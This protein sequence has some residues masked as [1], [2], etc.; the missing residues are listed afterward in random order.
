MHPIAQ[1]RT[2][3][4]WSIAWR[5]L[6]LVAVLLWCGCTAARRPP[7]ALASGAGGRS[8]TL[9][10]VR[11]S[12]SGATTQVVITGSGPMQPLVQRLSQPDRLLIELPYT[13]LPAPWNQGAI[14]VGDGRLKTMQTTH[15]PQTG[16]SVVLT[17]NAIRDYRV[18]VQSAP[19]RVIVE[20]FGAETAVR[21]RRKAH[22]AGTGGKKSVARGKATAAAP[23]HTPQPPPGQGPLIVIDPGHGGHDPGTQGVAGVVE[24]TVVLQIA[25]ALRQRIRE[26]MPHYRVMLTRNRDVFIPLGER[27]RM[28]NVAKARVFISIHANSSPNREASGL[29]VW[30]LSFAASARAKQIAAR[31][32]MLS[33]Q[34]QSVL[35]RILRDMQETD[36]INQSAVLAQTTHKA[37]V[38]HLA[39][40][41]PGLTPRGVEGAPF[42]VL[43]RTQMPS[44]LIETGFLSNAEEEARLRTPQYQRLL[45][46]GIVRGLHQFLHSAVVAMR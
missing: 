4:P 24:K 8:T 21:P 23:R 35:E 16:V 38:E 7:P 46:E 3:V 19:H 2:R 39:T 25:H 18:G 26:E 28:A 13:R 36:H 40:R 27:A 9:S 43:H 34:Q 37:T 42:A 14:T 33:G 45:V 30:Y 31:E 32:N 20:L 41:Y 5:L 6:T 11:P 22:L 10:G 1:S 17:V 12:S 44:I 15:N 29:E